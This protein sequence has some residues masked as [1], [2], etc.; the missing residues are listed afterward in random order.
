M[1]GWHISVYRQTDDGLLPATAESASGT[2]LAVW[3][4]G[5]NGLDWITELVRANEAVY[6][7]GNGYPIRFTA[8]AKDLLPQLIDQPPDA[9]PIWISDKDDILTEKWE[10][11]TVIDHLAVNACP[12]GEWLLVEAWDES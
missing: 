8:P 11:R 9:N 5:L 7:G 3:Q 6:L 2:R 1:L 4:T 10:G 12:P